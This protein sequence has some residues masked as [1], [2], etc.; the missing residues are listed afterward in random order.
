VSAGLDL[1]DSLDLASVGRCSVPELFG[2]VLH[3]AA[4]GAG[5]T[6]VV[7][8]GLRRQELGHV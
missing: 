3:L 7:E 8:L 1:L 5:N 2:W 4:D 6:W